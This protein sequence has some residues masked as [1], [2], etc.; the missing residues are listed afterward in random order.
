MA[1]GAHASP[2]FAPCSPP[3]H[4]P[5]C[6]TLLLAL[7]LSPATSLLL[8]DWYASSCP[9]LL[10]SSLPLRPTLAT[11]DTDRAQ[12][13]LDSLPPCSV[14][15][16][17]CRSSA[18]C[19]PGAPSTCSTKWS[20]HLAGYG[21]HPGHPARVDGQLNRRHGGAQC[22]LEKIVLDVP[23]SASFPIPIQ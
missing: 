14:S 2:T 1:G 12:G 6:L 19:P 16:S 22:Q 9:A 23:S 7:P 18:P 11:A 3:T 4:T 10:L 21:A 5:H 20:S 13:L 17:W 8:L 15:P